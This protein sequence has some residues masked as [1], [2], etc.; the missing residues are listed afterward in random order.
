MSRRL[1]HDLYKHGGDLVPHG[2]SD[3]EKRIA[4]GSRIHLTAARRMRARR[5]PLMWDTA[6]LCSSIPRRERIVSLMPDAV[7]SRRSRQTARELVARREDATNIA[8][9][10]AALV[11]PRWR[12]PAAPGRR[13]RRFASSR[14][15]KNAS[16]VFQHRLL[17][18]ESVAGNAEK[19]RWRSFSGLLDGLRD[20]AAAEAARADQQ[21]LRS[22]ADARTDALQ[23]R[24]PHALR[25]VVG[26]THVVA[27][28][29]LL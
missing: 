14:L 4:C 26:V 23:V 11:S 29:A 22:A 13:R 28:R 10:V 25:L 15:L 24:P 5:W 3:M 9:G 7:R 16:G 18:G 27:D 19:L 1:S 2:T 21:V 6:T 20:L 8:V 17:S 12:G